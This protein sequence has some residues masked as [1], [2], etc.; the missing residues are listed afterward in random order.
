MESLIDRRRRAFEPRF[1]AWTQA[2]LL[3]RPSEGIDGWGELRAPMLLHGVRVD[4]LPIGLTV[5]GAMG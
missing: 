5:L 4:D 3:D 1:R 2:F